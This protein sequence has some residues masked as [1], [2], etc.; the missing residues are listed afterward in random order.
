[1]VLSG[2]LRVLELYGVI[3]FAPIE[4][5]ARCEPP[6]SAVYTPAINERNTFVHIKNLKYLLGKGYKMCFLRVLRF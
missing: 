4:I 1:L 5:G 6:T 2:K 3:K